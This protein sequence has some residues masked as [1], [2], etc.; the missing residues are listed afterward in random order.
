MDWR[1][2]AA[3][4]KNDL[5]AL[6]RALD[7]GANPNS[8]DGGGYTALIY[9]VYNNQVSCVA[10][11]IEAGANP[12][13][14]PH[15]ASD[16]PLN[17]ASFMGYTN[18]IRVLLAGGAQVDFTSPSSQY[19]SPLRCAIRNGHLP[20]VRLLLVAGA[21][22][23]HQ[24]TQGIT[25]SPLACAV[26]WI[27]V[28]AVARRC[29]FPLLLRAGASINDP[30][31]TTLF[32][33]VSNY[34]EPHKR[35]VIE[36]L[37]AVHAAGGFPAYTRAHR[38][39]FAA[40]FSRGTRLPPDVIPNVVEYWASLGCYEYSVPGTGSSVAATEDVEEAADPEESSSS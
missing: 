14:H 10:R 8:S 6:S 20:A 30:E 1:I 36:Y 33:H 40:I 9:A 5:A 15:S 37:R 18:I 29:I 2:I 23:N 27:P 24:L 16:T 25:R 4:N 35:K 12:N 11:L 22:A 31:I 13:C 38:S 26:E 17:I 3:L 21:D 39:R 28:D 32:Q 7:D 19:R 34:T